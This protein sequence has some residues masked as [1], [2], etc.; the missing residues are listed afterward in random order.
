MNKFI[1]R[2]NIKYTIEHI[3]TIKNDLDD[4]VDT[5]KEYEYFL[6]DG[7][8]EP[9]N[10][11]PEIEDKIIA[12]E[13]ILD[14]LEY[15]GEYKKRI[16]SKGQE[17]LDTIQSLKEVVNKIMTTNETLNDIENYHDELVEEL[18]VLEKQKFEKKMNEFEKNVKVEKLRKLRSVLDSEERHQLEEWTGMKIDEIIFHSDKEDNN[19]SQQKSIFD[20]IVLNKSHLIFLIEDIHGNTFGGY[21]DAEI[22]KVDTY[23]QDPNAFLF[24]LKSNRRLDGFKRYPI[25]SAYNQYVF[26]LHNKNHSLLFDFGYENDLVIHKENTKKNSYCNQYRKRGNIQYFDY[27]NIGDALCGSHYPNCFTPKKIVVLQCISHM[28]NLNNSNDNEMKE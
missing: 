19:W 28:N 22:T 4:F 10:E 21:L 5:F 26:C 13:N 20:S 12:C 3:Q 15:L 24:T 11:S 17:L 7:F 2:E 18:I 23:I 14:K 27:N 16:D 25:L 1:K 6:E 9:T 8:F